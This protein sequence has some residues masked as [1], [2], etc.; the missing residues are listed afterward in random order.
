MGQLGEMNWL[1]WGG[2]CIKDCLSRRAYYRGSFASWG[3][4]LQGV[5]S[6]AWFP[7]E[8]ADWSAWVMEPS[9][10]RE[11]L[12]GG[13]A[14]PYKKVFSLV[15]LHPFQATVPELQILGCFLCI[16]ELP[17]EGFFYQKTAVNQN[18]WLVAAQNASMAIRDAPLLDGDNPFVMLKWNPPS[19]K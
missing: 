19:S 6:Q 11:A 12:V 15:F 16:S 18:Q 8:K 14:P 17:K 7:T 13:T 4:W 3:F 1:L 10:Q 5:V 2:G 9:G